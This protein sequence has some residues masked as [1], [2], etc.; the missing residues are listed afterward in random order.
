M[1]QIDRRRYGRFLSP[2][3]L[4]GVEIVVLEKREFLGTRIP[5]L[6]LFPPVP[7]HANTRVRMLLL[8]TAL[9]SGP[10]YSSAR[11]S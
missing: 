11:F 5:W 9:S 10:V 2:P 4:L 6:K 7:V 1:F 8:A 3:R